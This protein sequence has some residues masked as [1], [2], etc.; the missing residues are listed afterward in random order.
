MI[1]RSPPIER[2]RRRIESLADSPVNVLITGESG[3]GKELIA[4]AIHTQGDR[5]GCFVV[6]DCPSLS[7]DSAEEA[8]RRLSDDLE[9]SQPSTPAAPRASGPTLFVK[10]AEHLG[11]LA[12]AKLARIVRGAKSD[13]NGLPNPVRII[14]SARQDLRTA[15][16]AGAF[17][18]DLFYYGLSVVR[19]ATVPLRAMR[20]DIPLLLEAFLAE[21]AQ[22]IRSEGLRIRRRAAP[23]PR[24]RVA[25]QRPGTAQRCVA[26]RAWAERGWGRSQGRDRP[27]S[28]WPRQVSWFEKEIIVHQLRQQRGNI[29]AASDVLAVPKTTLYEKLQKFGISLSA[30]K[31]REAYGNVGGLQEA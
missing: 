31:C 7:D 15:C 14:A 17:L 20:E 24:A 13:P 9:R 28:P 1:G 22:R 26:L 19:L 18:P 10:N 29:G 16:E 27:P 4:R 6:I 11:T 5:A 8:F 25:G 21:A 2:L 3:T 23:S 30:F 12:Q